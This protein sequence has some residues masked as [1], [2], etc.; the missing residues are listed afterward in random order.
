M[1]RR[2]F[3]PADSSCRACSHRLTSS[4]LSRPIE[5]KE[6]PRGAEKIRFAWRGNKPPSQQEHLSLRHLP[7]GSRIKVEAA[8]SRRPQGG[9]ENIPKSNLATP[10]PKVNFRVFPCLRLAAAAPVVHAGTCNP[11]VF[12]LPEKSSLESDTGTQNTRNTFIIR[13]SWR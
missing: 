4:I 11:R 9:V 13:R 2:R 1:Q 6:E 12:T 5:P 7:R 3:L 8:S 10:I